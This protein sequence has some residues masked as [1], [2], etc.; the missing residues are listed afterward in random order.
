[1]NSCP[2]G[3]HL[4]SDEE[5]KKLEVELGMK[6]GA[7]ERG[8]RGTRPGQGFLLK[9]GGGTNFDAKLAGY[10]FWKSFDKIDTRGYFWTST[11]DSKNLYWI[12]ELSSFAS[13]KRD[14][15]ES[16][17]GLSVRCI[18]GNPDEKINVPLEKKENWFSYFIN[19]NQPYLSLGVGSGSSY[20]DIGL[21]LQG[22]YDLG[23][24]GFAIS[25]GFGYYDYTLHAH[26]GTTYE[27]ISNEERVGYSSVGFKFFYYK[28]LYI[29]FQEKK[30]EIINNEHFEYWDHFIENISIGGD[31]SLGS[32]FSLNLGIGYNFNVKEKGFPEGHQRFTYDVGISY[33]ILK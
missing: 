12:R 8:W 4:P 18:Q 1:M 2:D 33:K 24:I 3:W 14:S 9:R 17:Y 26:P 32:N 19:D 13:V 5:W 25:L 23:N 22:K 20:G 7:D 31:F 29:C 10:S 15:K 28:A 16:L 11:N 6:T 21:R 27:Y 30:S